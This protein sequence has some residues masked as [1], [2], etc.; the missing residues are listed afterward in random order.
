MISLINLTT[1]EYLKL[2]SFVDKNVF[3]QV[4]ITDTHKERSEE[5]LQKA[6][7]KFSIFKIDKGSVNNER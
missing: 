7:I 5:I 4:F 6:G 1:I 3:G 2:I